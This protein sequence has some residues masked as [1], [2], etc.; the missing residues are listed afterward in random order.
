[1][2]TFN[3]VVS[4]GLIGL[5]LG[6]P[7]AASFDGVPEAPAAAVP[8]PNSATRDLSRAVPL[9]NP[10]T[11]DLDRLTPP[12][13]GPTQGLRSGSQALQSGTRALREGKADEAVTELEYAARQG[14]P[15]AIWK[16]GRMYADG[17]GVGKN[18]L[19]SF[20]YFRDLTTAHAYDP[21]NAPQARFV[22]NAFVALGH[23]Y[24]DG[25][26]ETYV[27]ADPPRARQ[28]YSYAASYFADPEAQYHLA[29]LY[30]DGKGGQKDARQAVR[31]LG[32]AANKGHHHAQATLGTLLFEGK[33]VSR[34]AAMGL[35]WLTVARDGASPNERWITDTYASAFAQAS[36][37]ERDLAYRYLQNWLGGRR[38]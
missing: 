3:V 22:A 6:L 21:P 9:A 29:R 7:P 13:P 2:R 15:G 24:L 38:R 31:W 20:E 35:F 33:Q 4:L 14:L 17:D 5:A 34:Q 18:M 28:L 16:L 8:P 19:R 37:D 10:T 26:P 27:K 36:D 11:R 12:A 23:F 1:M 30:L 32:N 25:I